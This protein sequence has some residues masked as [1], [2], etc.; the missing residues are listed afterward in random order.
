MDPSIWGPPLWRKMHLKT[1]NYP[2]SPSHKDKINMIKYFNNIANVLQCE[3]CR[4]HYIRELM[5][6]PVTEHV[7][8][9]KSVIKWLINL[10]NK[11]N[12]RLGKRVLSYKEVYA[13]YEI[14]YDNSALFATT[15][16]CTAMLV[17]LGCKR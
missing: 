15:I 10:H 8:S 9:R 5:L 2:E 6:N 16:F 14:P 11:V 7:H 13:I 17:L 3:K 12:R 4:K 1:F